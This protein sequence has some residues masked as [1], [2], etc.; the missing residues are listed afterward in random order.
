MINTRTMMA[1]LGGIKSPAE[2]DTLWSRRM[3]DQL[4]YG[5]SYWAVE[6]RETGAILGSCGIR[7]ADNYRHTPVA[8]MAELGWRI[9]EQH[10]N[11]GYA[12][13]AAEAAIGWGW[14]HLA[15]REMGAWTTIGN[16]RSW[17]LMER[18]GMVRRTD[19]DFRHRAFAEDDP[20][21]AMIV[22]TLARPE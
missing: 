2:L 18:L 11:R 8:G 6:L 20:L 19:L 1:K 5:H 7:I 10:W 15:A 9:A 12:R 4:R 22:Y 16:E 17:R 3:S 14:A 21:G 13:E